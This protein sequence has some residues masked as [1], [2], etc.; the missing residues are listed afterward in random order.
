MTFFQLGMIALQARLL[1]MRFGWGNSV[2]VV[3][4]L[5]GLATWVWVVPHL[6]EQ[7]NIQRQCWLRAQQSRQADESGMPAERHTTAEENF[8][9]F[10]AV[11]GDPLDTEKQIKTLF[12]LARKTGLALSQAEYKL[13]DDKNGRYRTYQILL[14]VKGSYSAI[15]NFCEKALL[16]IPFASLDEMGFKRESIATGRLEARLRFTLYLSEFSHANMKEDRQDSRSFKDA[17]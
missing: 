3:L 15:R 11:L 14:P 10:S 6:N 2:A 13:A 1:V 12:S 17:S 5:A 9:R 4:C 8:N 16:E 7:Q